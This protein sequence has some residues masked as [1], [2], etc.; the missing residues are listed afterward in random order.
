MTDSAL[1]TVKELL[2][3]KCDFSFT[4]LKFNKESLEYGA[5]SFELN[6]KIVEYRDSK[7]TPT[8]TGQFVTIWKRNCHGV[9]A[10][11]DISDGIDFVVITSKSGESIGQ[12]IFPMS[13]LAQKGIVSQN[14]KGGKRGIRVY[15]SWDKVTNKQAEKIQN[16]QT[17]YFVLL[18]QNQTD[19]DLTKKL[20][21]GKMESLYSIAKK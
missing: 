19:T 17:K 11:F 2:Y 13:V 7:I 12:F 6:G 20:F 8:K 18:D 10:P 4:N 15:P 1:K 16:W 3:D 14:G 21:N 9:T 5:C